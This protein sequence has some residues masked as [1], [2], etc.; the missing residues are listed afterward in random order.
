[1]ERLQE[2]NTTVEANGVPLQCLATNMTLFDPQTFN[3]L[4]SAFLEAVPRPP[5]SGR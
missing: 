2:R 5:T 4:V 3:Q 1:M